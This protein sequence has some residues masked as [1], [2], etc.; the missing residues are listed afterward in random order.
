MAR[1]ALNKGVKVAQFEI[2]EEL[3]QDDMG[4]VYSG[5][6]TD[7]QDGPEAVW[8]REF[9]PAR[10]TR[11]RGKKVC[12]NRRE[13]QADLNEA[14]S[15]EA[16]KFERLVKMRSPGRQE[17]IDLVEAHG[18]I[19]LICRMVRGEPLA[20][21]LSSAGKFSPGF[22]RV[23]LNDVMPA[24]QAFERAKLVHGGI[25]SETLV[26]ADD[27]KTRVLAPL[28]PRNYDKEPG[29]AQY[30]TDPTPFQAPEFFN[31][32]AGTTGPAS[33]VYS[34]CA[35]IYHLITGR[36]PPSAVMRLEAMEAG[37]ADPLNL[38]RLETHLEDDPDLFAALKDGLRLMVDERLQSVAKLQAAM[39][40][41][42]VDADLKEDEK[43][44][45]LAVG[46][47]APGWWEKYGRSL[48]AAGAV[49][50]L[51]MVAIPVYVLFGAGADTETEIV[52][53]TE[54]S[55]E[56]KTVDPKQTETSDVPENTTVIDDPPEA[57][58][59]SPAIPETPA[60][61]PAEVVEADEQV[62]PSV[63]AWLE[64]DQSDPDAILDFM[65]TPDLDEG[66][67]RQARARWRTLEEDAWNVARDDGSPEAMQAFLQIYGDDPPAFA[68][69]KLEAETYLA[70][71]Q[72]ELAR[73]AEAA[74][75]ASETETTAQEELP[76]AIS[77]EA[78]P[79]DQTVP[80]EAD[81]EAEEAAAPE[82]SDEPFQ[83][84][85]VKDC[86]NCPPVLPV[87]LGGEDLAVAVH[88]VT[89]GEYDAY[90][91]ATG[92]AVSSGCFAHKTGTTSIWGYDSQASYTAPGYPVLPDNPAVCVSFTEAEAYA[93]WLSRT[94]GKSYRLMTADEWSELAG[95]VSPA[96]LACGGGNFAD[97]SLTAE[98]VQL[99]GQSCSDGSAF[100]SKTS[101]ET[102]RVT[103]LYGN[104]EEWVS[105]C[106]EGDCSKRLAMGGSW[107]SVPGQIRG[108]LR[109]TY[110]SGS[111]SSTL[112]FR[113]V[114]DN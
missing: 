6:D 10:L 65:S 27:G 31:P 8:V 5:F 24:L 28:T 110:T 84:G 1:K 13:L 62:S 95:E 91:A 33:D 19:Y 87:V 71:I 55:A 113:V 26:R 111:R 77:S 20:E 104:V 106:V 11:R 9:A 94:T 79:V 46:G 18:T 75:E 101:A 51:L 97:G 67:R 2:V 53:A 86:A 56:L 80:E 82:D 61:V 14:M 88:E 36:L 17:A 70:D 12:P 3:S 96:A 100:T 58:G 90:I 45:G 40:L 50:T 21:I 108:N 64:V 48:V 114:R 85:S 22:S 44:A 93:S 15:R 81:T 59:L 78:D 105:D 34:L 63:T 73:D 103:A 109:A 23:L 43:S 25:S 107:A 99:A 35:S 68:S 69:Y 57:E 74:A 7:S 76:D 39:Y 98:D 47:A 4:F 60:D 102:D 52:P 16:I 66:V 92:R 41:T 29:E 89:I 72:E 49:L 37:E 54:K 38:P 83:A 112:G 30:L 32:L 42:P